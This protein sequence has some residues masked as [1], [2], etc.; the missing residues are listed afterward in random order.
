MGG[1]FF[2]QKK[3]KFILKNEV[4]YF[5]DLKNTVLIFLEEFRAGVEAVGR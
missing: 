3:L 4:C 2:K 1:A 5:D